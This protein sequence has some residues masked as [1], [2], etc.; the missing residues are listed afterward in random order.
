[1]GLK[2]SF[3]FFI[4]CLSASLFQVLVAN[5]LLMA[6]FFSSQNNNVVDCSQSM[7]CR[8][9]KIARSFREVAARGN[10]QSGF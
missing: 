2:H 9:M 3:F 4:K 8:E 10:K 6:Q 7:R 5:L 1:M